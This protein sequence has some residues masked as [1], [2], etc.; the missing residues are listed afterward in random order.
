MHKPTAENGRND[1]EETRRPCICSTE[2]DEG[3]GAVSAGSEDDAVLADTPVPYMPDVGMPGMRRSDSSRQM[4]EMS[5]IAGG[6]LGSIHRSL[7]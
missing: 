4:Q 6:K 7:A 2:G 1:D 3:H 5:R